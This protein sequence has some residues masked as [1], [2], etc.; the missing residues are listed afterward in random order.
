MCLQRFPNIHKKHE[1]K[2]TKQNKVNV[3]AANNCFAT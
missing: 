3:I 1:G 2:K